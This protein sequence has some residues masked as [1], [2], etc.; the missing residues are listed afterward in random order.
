MIYSVRG[1]L[2]HIE[3]NLAVVECGGV[4][5]KC[6]TTANTLAALP[7]LGGEARLLTWLQVREDGVELFGF[8][9]ERELASFKMLISVSGVG[10]KA[11]LSILSDLSPEKFALCVA[12]GDAKLLTRSQGIGQKI[13]QRIVLELRDKISKEQLVPQGGGEIS[14]K[15]LSQG[16]MA[17]AISALAVLGYSQSE[18]AAAVSS[19]SPDT[20]VEELIKSGLKALSSGR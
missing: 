1:K 2:I 18:A 14:P 4:G 3:A 6:L 10:P 12:S 17:E 11:A 5:Y 20:P 19:L 13:A 8:A 16:N 9:D 7:Q 15:N